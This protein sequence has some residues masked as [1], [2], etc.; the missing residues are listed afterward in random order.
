MFNSHLVF[1]FFALNDQI[2]RSFYDIDYHFMCAITIHIRSLM[3]Y[4]VFFYVLLIR[5]SYPNAMTY[6][7]FYNSTQLKREII[8]KKKTK[9]HS[10][11]W[12]PFEWLPI[13]RLIFLSFHFIEYFTATKTVNKIYDNNTSLLLLFFILIFKVIEYTCHT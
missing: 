6:F 8:K 12:K 1:I 10:E 5:R 13:F 4:F 2:K 3:F 11:K 7:H 9:S